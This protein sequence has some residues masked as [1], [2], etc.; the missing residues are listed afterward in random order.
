MD[1]SDGVVFRWRRDL[2]MLQQ[3]LCAHNHVLLHRFLHAFRLFPQLLRGCDW[4][5]GQIVLP[6]LLERH[7]LR[8]MG[9]EME[10]ISA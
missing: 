3:L 5:C 1:A 4:L 10:P 7:Q 6:R 2:G 9:P 8:R